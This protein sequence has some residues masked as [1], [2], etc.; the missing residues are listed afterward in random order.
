MWSRRK[1]YTVCLF[2]YAICILVIA[3]L[4][5]IRSYGIISNWVALAG[6]GL[7]L[8]SALGIDKDILMFSYSKYQER[9]L[10]ERRGGTSQ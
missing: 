4:E 10:Q 1:F 5:I 6:L 7:L 2:Y 9:M 8:G 3:G